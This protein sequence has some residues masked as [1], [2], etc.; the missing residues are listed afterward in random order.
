MDIMCGWTD[1]P[2]HLYSDT[3]RVALIDRGDGFLLTPD[4]RLVEKPTFAK[5][6]VLDVLLMAVWRRKSKYAVIIH[7]DQWSQFS[8]DKWN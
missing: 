6:I 1:H 7:P 3:R 2:H 4:H 8:S 5:E